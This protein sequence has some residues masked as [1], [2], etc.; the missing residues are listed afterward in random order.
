M[1]QGSRNEALFMQKRR[2]DEIG[3]LVHPQIAGNH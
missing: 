2:A 3:F 1:S